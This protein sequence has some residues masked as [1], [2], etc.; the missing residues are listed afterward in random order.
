MYECKPET[1]FDPLQLYNI[2]TFT[3]W[4]TAASKSGPQNQTKKMQE[5]GIASNIY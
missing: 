5:V 3:K 2:S 1:S 4:E